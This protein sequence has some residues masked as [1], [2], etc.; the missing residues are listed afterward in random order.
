MSGNDCC[1]LEIKPRRGRKNWLEECLELRTTSRETWSL[2]IRTVIN[3]ALFNSVVAVVNV[4]FAIRLQVLYRYVRL[5]HTAWVSE[6]P[7]DT[8]RLWD[9]RAS[10]TSRFRC[11]ITTQHR[12]T[13]RRTRR[14]TNNEICRRQSQLAGWRPVFLLSRRCGSCVA[15]ATLAVAYLQVH[16]VNSAM[17]RLYREHDVLLTPTDQFSSLSKRVVRILL[18]LREIHYSTV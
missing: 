7:S 9:E 8:A 5:R 16:T 4:N 2:D 6:R 1:T 11:R 12:Q 14:G 17:N 15:N 13:D 3:T 18:L 10:N